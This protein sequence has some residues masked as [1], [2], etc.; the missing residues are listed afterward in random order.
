MDDQQPKPML[1]TPI[2]TEVTAVDR[3]YLPPELPEHEKQ[4][5]EQLKQA[6]CARFGELTGLTFDWRTGECTTPGTV[7]LEG[8]LAEQ[9]A[10]LCARLGEER[11][12]QK[13]EQLWRDAGKLMREAA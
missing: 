3:S 1:N 2:E 12:A 6:A 7:N 10:A 4:R 11:D 5:I 13:V 8:E 9:W